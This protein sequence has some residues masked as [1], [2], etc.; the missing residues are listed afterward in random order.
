MSKITTNKSK[1]K[2]QTSDVTGVNRKTTSSYINGGLRADVTGIKKQTN[3]IIENESS[4]NTTNKEYDFKFHEVV[5]LLPRLNETQKNDLRA[6]LERLSRF[7][8]VEGSQECAQFELFIEVPMFDAKVLLSKDIMTIIV[9][10]SR[11]HAYPLQFINTTARDFIN[12]VIE[13]NSKYV[14]YTWGQDNLLCGLL[15]TYKLPAE[16]APVPEAPAVEAVEAPAVSAAVE[17][18]SEMARLMA[19]AEAKKADGLAK[20]KVKRDKT[21]R[22]AVA[23]PYRLSADHSF[24]VHALSNNIE[25]DMLRFS[26]LTDQ[27]IELDHQRISLCA[28]DEGYLHQMKNCLVLDPTST[29]RLLSLQAAVMKNL[30]VVIHHPLY[31][32][33]ES[34]EITHE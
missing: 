3:P 6:L 21:L 20:H 23:A 30:Q 25:R 19:L 10:V 11:K 27:I 9:E 12:G 32:I 13:S 15:D 2:H 22:T 26:K 34:K 7:R 33:P 29:E 24:S 1:K 14:T 18:A 4:M 17:V 31:T 28:S 5:D 8:L 16:V